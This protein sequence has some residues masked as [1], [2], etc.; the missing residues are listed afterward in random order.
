MEALIQVT[1]VG[2]WVNAALERV[3]ECRCKILEELKQ[4]NKVVQVTV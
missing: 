1:G 4:T 2:K 3:K